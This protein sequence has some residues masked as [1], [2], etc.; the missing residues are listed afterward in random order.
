MSKQVVKLRE[1]KDDCIL[2]LA[3]NGDLFFLGVPKCSCGADEY[4]QGVKDALSSVK[5]EG[6]KSCIKDQ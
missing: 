3:R 4:N 6:K 1:H 5:E 2:K